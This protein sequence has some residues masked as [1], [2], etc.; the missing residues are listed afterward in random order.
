MQPDPATAE[1]RKVDPCLALLDQY[2]ACVAQH[3]KGLSEGDD[4]TK[5]ASAYKTCRRS[6]KQKKQ[7][8][9]KE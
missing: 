6:E 9:K 2:T 3:E 5:E 4:C 7:E 1:Q 8:E